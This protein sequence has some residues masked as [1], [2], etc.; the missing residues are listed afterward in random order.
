MLRGFANLEKHLE[1]VAKFKLPAVVAIN[2]FPNDTTEEIETLRHA[3]TEVG[4]QSAIVT[5][6]EDGGKGAVDLAEKIVSAVD[7]ANQFEPLYPLD[8]TVEEK[9]NR[10]SQEIYG[11]SGVDFSTEAK[12]DLKLIE[13]LNLTQLP[14]CIAKTQYSLSDN[15]EL[16]GKP[17]NFTIKVRNIGISS[18]AGFLVPFTGAI[19][20]MPGLPK[21]PSAESI[22]IDEN[23]KITGLL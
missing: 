3:I 10:V 9:I 23:G 4:A 20:L 6:F 7:H 19:M 22:D 12:V 18:G 1:N 17:Q 11:A 2:R 15:P 14:V 5:S 13:R 21:T 16:L 8:S